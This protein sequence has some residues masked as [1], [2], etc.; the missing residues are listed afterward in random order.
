M[1]LIPVGGVPLTPPV[2]LSGRAPRTERE[3]ALGSVTMED[4]EAAV[5]KEVALQIPTG[6][7]PLRF[8]VVGTT[9]VT[10]GF[11]HNVGHGWRGEPCQESMP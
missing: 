6:E 9:M 11:E 1:A 8:K 5:G 2:L 7:A 3:I 4:A 10:D